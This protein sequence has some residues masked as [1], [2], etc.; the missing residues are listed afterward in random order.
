M[1][2][3]WISSGFRLNW[4]RG[5]N[6]EKRGYFERFEDFSQ[7]SLRYTSIEEAGN[8]K[9]IITIDIGDGRK[10]ELVVCEDDDPL[11]LAK[12]F[13]IKHSLGQAACKALAEQI[14][15]NLDLQPEDELSTLI[16]VNKSYDVRSRRESQEKS[17]ISV[18]NERSSKVPHKEEKPSPDCKNSSV[19]RSKASSPSPI[20]NY[21]Q[22]LYMKGLRFIQNVEQKKHKI[23]EEQVEKEMK[24]VTFRPR[25]NQNRSI[26]R[27]LVEDFLLRKGKEK[28]E[29]IERK[30]GEKLAEEL[31]NCT[32][33][34][35]ICKKSEKINKGQASP[36]RFMHLYNNAKVVKSKVTQNNEKM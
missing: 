27:N 9:L 5:Y 18:I 34:P 17:P 2:F 12:E 26:D 19:D 35:N 3:N 13:C 30:R 11:T 15:Q 24:N 28:Q 6:M 23:S 7:D 10:D 36:N 16:S 4:P 29:H 22:K 21:G 8:E 20:D 32:F 33:S 14:E 31:S 25:I 1:G